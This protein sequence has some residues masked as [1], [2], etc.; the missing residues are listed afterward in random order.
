MKYKKIGRRPSRIM[1]SLFLFA[2]ILPVISPNTTYASFEGYV[3]KDD[4][5]SANSQQAPSGAKLSGVQGDWL[6][7][8]TI[9]NNNAQQ[10][11]NYLTQTIGFS[12][13]GAAG[14][15]AV[16]KRESNF[17]PQALN[18][19]GGV[20]GWFQWS[21]FTNT[22]NGSRITAEGSIKAGDK[23]TL[24]AE[25][26]LKLIAFELN[27]GWKNA[28]IVVGN[29]IDPV[30]AAKDWSLYYEGV[31]LSDGQSKIGQ[32][33]QDAQAA[34][35][36][37]G[38]ANIPANSALLGAAGA[39]NAGVKAKNPD[40]ENCSESTDS[41]DVLQIAKSLLGYF[42]YGQ[43][44]GVSYIG[45][46]ENPDRNGITD[47]SG[48]VWLVLKKAGYKVPENMGW[49][50]GS[51]EADAKGAHHWLTE[52]PAS[53]AKAGDVVIVNTGG[54]S[55]NNGHTAILEENW[56]SQSPSENTTKVI[57][58]GGKDGSGGVNEGTFR[59]S[60]L[61]LLSGNYTLTF[62]RPQK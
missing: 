21:G 62:A 9:A 8:G 32:I 25:N 10:I 4:C 18:P 59:E 50:T 2:L 55:G 5:D 22:V 53:E 51:M 49:F 43:S 31:S 14:A 24:T 56:K 26:E 46:V 3:A 29:D 15:L 41:S 12:G 33:T 1:S 27:G 35:V 7:K 45:S 23:G 58:M 57:Q 54:G 13:A 19:G 44:H 39:A 28:K 36:A 6:A 47:C 52:I 40:N 30:Q 42:H 34:Y 16:A 17:D 20:A 61:S 48:F 11:F 60:F 38:G 37:F